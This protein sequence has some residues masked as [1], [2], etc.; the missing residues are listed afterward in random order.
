MLQSS[1]VFTFFSDFL[2]VTITSLDKCVFNIIKKE[3]ENAC[4]RNKTQSF[5]EGRYSIQV[6]FLYHVTL[7]NHEQFPNRFFRNK[8]WLER[9]IWNSLAKPGI[10]CRS[11]WFTAFIVNQLRNCL[12][13]SFRLN[14]FIQVICHYK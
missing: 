9:P 6:N 11:R 2:L 12:P 3:L 14:T 8:I 1:Y 5:F 13:P 4:R 10:C 7:K